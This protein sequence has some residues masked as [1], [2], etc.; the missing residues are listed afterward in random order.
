MIYTLK[1][2]FLKVSFKTNLKRL[3]IILGKVINA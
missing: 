2:N 3:K 1:T